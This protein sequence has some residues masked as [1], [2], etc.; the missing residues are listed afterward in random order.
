MKPQEFAQGLRSLELTQVEFAS[1]VDASKR[2]V[3]YWT[4]EAVPGPVAALVRLL[5]ARPEMVQVLR[6]LKETSS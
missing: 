6:E 2:T 3:L 4:Q 5:L 1:L